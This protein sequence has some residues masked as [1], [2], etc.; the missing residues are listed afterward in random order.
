VDKLGYRGGGTDILR[1]LQVAVNEINSYAIH[2][3]TVVGEYPSY[4]TSAVESVLT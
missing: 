3:L 1:G 4:R 2:N